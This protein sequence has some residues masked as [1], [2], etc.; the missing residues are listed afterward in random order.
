MAD[1]T[2]PNPGPADDPFDE[3]PTLALLAKASP[4]L[5]V[6]FDLVMEA[7]LL[8]PAR[9]APR[10]GATDPEYVG[11]SLRNASLAIE[12]AEDVLS[13]IQREIGPRA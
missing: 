2:A 6:A 7:L 5:H 8:Q 10:A 13:R 1:Q 3:K 11:E 12:Q 9:R 4:L